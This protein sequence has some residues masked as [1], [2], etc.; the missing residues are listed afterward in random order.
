[1]Y[2]SW[3]REK[4]FLGPEDMLC[5]SHFIPRALLLKPSLTQIFSH[6]SP[7]QKTWAHSVCLPALTECLYPCWDGSITCKQALLQHCLSGHGSL[8]FYLTATM[9]LSNT[10]EAN[11][12]VLCRS[13]RVVEKSI[14]PAVSSRLVRD[15]TLPLVLGT[16]SWM[17]AWCP[18]N[19][20]DHLK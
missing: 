8:C 2:G 4:W 3:G 20:S 13:G 12:L 9:V 6:P 19:E 10:P 15:D 17:P 16:S 11:C 14:I 18:N 7:T 1:M 5:Y